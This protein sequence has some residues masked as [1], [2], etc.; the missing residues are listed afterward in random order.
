M[1][2]GRMPPPGPRESTDPGFDPPNVGRAPL[3]FDGDEVLELRPDALIRRSPDL[4]EVSRLA[5]ERAKDFALLRDRSLVVSVWGPQPVV[6]HVVGDKIV[7]TQPAMPDA[8]LPTAT[9]SSYWSIGGSVAR[10]DATTGKADARVWLPDNTYKQTAIAA[11]DGSVLIANL[12][13]ILRIDR[14]LE[15][16]AW[17][18][19]ASFLGPGADATHVWAAR[20][21]K[22]AWLE[23]A[24]D[25][26]IEKARFTLA[27]GEALLHFTASGTHAAAT[28][29][30][31]LEPGRASCTLIVFAGHGEQWRAELG[32]Y[33]I[34]QAAMSSTR[35][36]VS[37]TA[38]D[39]RMLR[40]WDVA[41]GKQL[42]GRSV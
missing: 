36:V 26:A 4:G 31:T 8:V 24:G 11:S 10:V 37:A 12:H 35:I 19:Q 3:V 5:L 40:T 20:S 18:E 30:R 21:A 23:L 1:P 17:S 7:A 13:G 16:Y 15:T 27:A 25:R 28:V 29:A 38:G 9:A 41:S 6:H 14:A 39:E 33:R 2:P 34:C 22:I 42:A 32:E